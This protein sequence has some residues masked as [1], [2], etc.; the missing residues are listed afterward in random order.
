MVPNDILFQI[1]FQE[2]TSITKDYILLT[3]ETYAIIGNINLRKGIN[4]SF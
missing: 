4:T 2:T 1:C 3:R